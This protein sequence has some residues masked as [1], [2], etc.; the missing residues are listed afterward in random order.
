MIDENLINSNEY[1][2]VLNI[3]PK[4]YEN[5]S[6]E[7]LIIEY[8]ENTYK[9]YEVIIYLPFYD[10]LE[11]LTDHIPII[12]VMLIQPNQYHTELKKFNKL[13]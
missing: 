13:T 1:V 8:S 4:L 2:C 12:P 5:K 7:R 3:L 9:L 10:V 11:S 6:V